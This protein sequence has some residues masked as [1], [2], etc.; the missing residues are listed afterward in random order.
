MRRK[1]WSPCPRL[2]AA[3]A[4]TVVTWACGPA[5]GP[6]CSRQTLDEP[7]AVLALV[8]P[9]AV[10][11]CNTP[12]RPVQLSTTNGVVGTVT[13]PPALLLIVTLTGLLGSLAKTVPW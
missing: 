7:V 8:A 6:L 10:E 11:R 3:T 4:L 2:G 9:A 1:S 12:G 13:S 5:Q